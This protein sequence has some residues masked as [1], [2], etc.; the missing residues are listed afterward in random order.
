MKKSL[1]VSV[2]CL[3]GNTLDSSTVQSYVPQPH[4]KASADV[5]T[6]YLDGHKLYNPQKYANNWNKSEQRKQEILQKIAATRSAIRTQVDQYHKNQ[7]AE[8]L[9][10]TIA[11]TMENRTLNRDRELKHERAQQLRV[12]A[13]LILVDV[14]RKRKGM[15]VVDLS[16]V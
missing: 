8:N 9:L 7:A 11:C 15:P 2:L 1:V 10:K 4:K 6:S 16:E 13:R 14:L 5:V 3:A 12:P